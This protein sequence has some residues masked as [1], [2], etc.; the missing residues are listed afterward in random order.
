MVDSTGTAACV[1]PWYYKEDPSL[2]GQWVMTQCGRH[3]ELDPEQFLDWSLLDLFGM[4]IDHQWEDMFAKLEQCCQEHGDCIV[5]QGF[6]K[7]PSLG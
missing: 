7:D 3:D 2:L 5:P 4:L 1:L 6:R